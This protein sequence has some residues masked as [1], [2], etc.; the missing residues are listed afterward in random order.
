[1]PQI[2]CFGDSIT[3]GS[4]DF[5]ESGWYG[6]LRRYMDARRDA[7]P[8]FYAL[9]YNLG[10]PAE[11][12]RGLVHRFLP[13]TEVR[14]GKKAKETPLFIFQFGAN[15]TCYIPSQEKFQVSKHE[16]VQNLA[17]VVSQAQDLGGQVI[18]LNI[19]PVNEV[20]T[21]QPEGQDKSRLNAYIEEYNEALAVFCTEKNLPL[22]DVYQRFTTETATDLLSERDGLHPTTKG[23]RIIFEAVKEKLPF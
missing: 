16:Y 6:H 10:I 2:F 19:T 5:A 9:T 4:H 23:H 21:G 3:Y 17:T 13:E 1:M 7:A 14:F 11:T 20:L 22:V 15:D 8:S 18:L 12:T